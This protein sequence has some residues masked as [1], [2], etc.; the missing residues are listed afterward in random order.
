MKMKKII[1]FAAV[2]CAAV[3]AQAAAV[4][5][6]M[7]SVAA[8]ADTTLTSGA[9]IGYFMD[10]STYDAFMASTDKGAYAA[11]NYTDSAALVVSRGKGSVSGTFG[12]YAAGDPVSGYIVIFDNAD[13]TKAGY[14]AVTAVQDKEVPASGGLPFTGEFATVTSGWQAL[15]SGT[16]SGGDIPEPTSGLLLVVG[17]ALLA[18]RRKQK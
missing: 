8:S 5:W 11:A 2:V 6:S 17:G 4:T 14:Y 18:L 1:V 13:V 16:T 7:T 15:G 12:D 10:G 9:M 3:V